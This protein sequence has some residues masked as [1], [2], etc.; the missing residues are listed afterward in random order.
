[1]Y[2][3]DGFDVFDVLRN[4]TL[5]PELEG[6]KFESFGQSID[7]IDNYEEPVPLLFNHL[8]YFR[9]DGGFEIG[10]IAYIDNYG[11]VVYLWEHRCEQFLPV[12]AVDVRRENRANIRI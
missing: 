4:L 11:A 12:E 3:F 7:F 8:E 5:D 9:N 2:A 1:M 6:V 10:S